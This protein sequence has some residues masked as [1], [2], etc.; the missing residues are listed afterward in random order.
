M[1]RGVRAS[2][3]PRTGGCMEDVELELTSISETLCADAMAKL[4]WDVREFSQNAVNSSMPI[5]DPTQDG[6]PIE[7]VRRAI[8]ALNVE[9]KSF[10]SQLIN[11]LSKTNPI[12][13]WLYENAFQNL[14]WHI[15]DACDVIIKRI[16]NSFEPIK[17]WD[18]HLIESVKTA[19]HKITNNSASLLHSYFQSRRASDECAEDRI[20]TALQEQWLR[21]YQGINGKIAWPVFRE[22]FPNVKKLTFEELFVLVKESRMRGRPMVRTH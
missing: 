20:A 10:L 7:H 16:F 15:G 6:I 19:A 21:E 14:A 5:S 13:D 8:V 18:T 12:T 9:A 11:I 2:R 1:A 4:R 17:N 22:R 3:L